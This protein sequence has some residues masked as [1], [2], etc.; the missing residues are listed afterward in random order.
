MQKIKNEQ[1]SKLKNLQEKRTKSLAAKFI[2]GES[3]VTY[4]PPIGYYGNFGAKETNVEGSA[5]NVDDDDDDDENDAEVMN[6]NTS[7]EEYVRLK[8][9]KKGF[10]NNEIVFSEDDNSNH[11]ETLC[12]N[13]KIAESTID[14]ALVAV[15]NLNKS[16]LLDNNNKENRD[17]QDR[18]DLKENRDVQDR[19]DLKEIR[20]V[21]DRPK[22]I[23]TDD[24]GK[25]YFYDPNW[26]ERL[27]SYTMDKRGFGRH[28]EVLEE[29]AEGSEQDQTLLGVL[30]QVITANEDTTLEYEE[31]VDDGESDYVSQGQGEAED[32]ESEEYTNENSGTESSGVCVSSSDILSDTSG[33]ITEKRDDSEYHS[34]TSPYEDQG[35]ETC[36]K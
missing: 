29:M 14:S 17:V 4:R 26:R 30:N 24:S 28:K 22:L 11:D 36:P 23:K 15:E 32:E 20:D 7:S 13:L 18:P 25:K 8:K 2:L 1:R 12:N 31:N 5:A 34:A 16:D 33:T 27:G 10:L 21:Q 6:E 9:P 19:P 3:S 35:K